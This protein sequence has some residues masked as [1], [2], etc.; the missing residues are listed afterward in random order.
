MNKQK[1]E[2]LIDLLDDTIQEEKEFVGP[3]DA[4]E[5]RQSQIRI[6]NFNEIKG[7]VEKYEKLTEAGEDGLNVFY[8]AGYEQGE[9][10]AQEPQPQPDEELAEKI[11]RAVVD[12]T[13][14]SVHGLDRDGA[15]A[16]IRKLL[17][18]EK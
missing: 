4:E 18:G 11:V 10:D 16:E 8:L 13:Y 9:S 1:M 7:I 17:K 3:E 14:S 12:N 2:E 15:K 6:F 5:Y